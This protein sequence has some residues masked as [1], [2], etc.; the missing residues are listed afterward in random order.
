TI[1][2]TGEVS[3]ANTGAINL[4]G[5]TIVH[6]GNAFKWSHANTS[7]FG[8]FGSISGGEAPFLSFHAEHSATANVLQNS[9]AGV[10]GLY[11]VHTGTSFDL[12]WNG[13]ATASAAFSGDVTAFS[14]SDAGIANFGVELREANN[15]VYSAG[16]P[17][18]A[19]A[20]GG[21]GASSAA[22]AR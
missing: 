2:D 20:D 5:L 17:D 18:V 16:G 15:R 3:I 22:S 13:V 1:S 14:I 8:A 6:S 11:L 21:T 4:H 9:G 12:V 7:F 19:V 10:K